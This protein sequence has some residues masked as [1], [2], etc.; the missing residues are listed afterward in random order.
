MICHMVHENW[1]QM[2]P[3]ADSD[4]EFESFQPEGPQSESEPDSEFATFA[5]KFNREAKAM[6]Y[7][8]ID[9]NFSESQKWTSVLLTQKAAASYL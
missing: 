2:A 5:K 7:S 4:S 1:Q 3:D 6:S 8:G 9:F